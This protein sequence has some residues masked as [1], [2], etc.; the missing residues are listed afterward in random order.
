MV[1]VA[2]A[3]VQPEKRNGILL[4]KL[5]RPTVRKNCSSVPKNLLKFEAEGR[6]L[7]KFLRSLEQNIQTVKGQKNCW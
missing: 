3:V 4:S 7:S 2:M 1:E 6:E 5:F